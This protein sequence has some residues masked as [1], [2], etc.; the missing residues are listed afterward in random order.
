MA[1]AS[2]GC[3]VHGPRRPPDQVRIL[4]IAQQRTRACA[5]ETPKR[6]ENAESET[7]TGGAAAQTSLLPA[8]TMLEQD[9]QAGVAVEE[10]LHLGRDIDHAEA[11]EE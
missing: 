4:G 7:G 11:S 10:Q 6:F 2:R 1:S 3:T 5:R 8:R 9:H